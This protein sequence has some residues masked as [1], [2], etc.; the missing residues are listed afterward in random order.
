MSNLNLCQIIGRVGKDPEVKYLPNGNA[1]ANFSVAVSEKWKD[2]NGNPQEATEW[3]SVV[4]FG[5][6]AELAGQ[7]VGKGSRIYLSGKIKTRSWDKDGQKH[8]KTELHA[9]QMQFIDRK[10]ADAPPETGHERQQRKAGTAQGRAPAAAAAGPG[11]G[12]DF[13]DDIPFAPYPSNYAC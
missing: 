9:D 10:D 5:K 2:K 12:G 6:T 13:Y 1:V 7:F 8:Y 4:M 11:G 3:F